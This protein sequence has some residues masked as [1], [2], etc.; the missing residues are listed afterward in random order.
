MAFI[1]TAMQLSTTRR[2][3]ALAR[4][5]K[6]MLIERGYTVK[7][8]SIVDLYGAR[9]LPLDLTVNDVPVLVRL[10]HD[11]HDRWQDVDYLEKYPNAFIQR[12]ITDIAPLCGH[13]ATVTGVPQ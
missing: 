8:R 11:T 10:A 12:G 7:W 9:L 2:E 13:I 5:L 6:M 1:H 4:K 3:R